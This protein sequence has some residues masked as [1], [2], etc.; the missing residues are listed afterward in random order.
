[1]CVKGGL[2]LGVMIRKTGRGEEEEGFPNAGVRGSEASLRRLASKVLVI[3][4]GV[5]SCGLPRGSTSTRR[6][7]REG[8]GGLGWG[9]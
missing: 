8:L 7:E 1:M 3:G 2:G 9:G 6:Y 4:V 5:Q